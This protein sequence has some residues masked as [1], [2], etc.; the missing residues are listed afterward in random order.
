MGWW[1]ISFRKVSLGHSKMQNLYRL[2]YISKNCFVGT[3]E[4]QKENVQSILNVA[5][6]NN[7]KTGVTGALLWSGD[8]F[9]QVIEGERDT[10]ED[11]FET[12][13]MD[14]RHEEIT[15]LHFEPIDRRSFSEWA[16][17]MAGNESTMRFDIEGI[18]A[19]KDE[20]LM[21]ETGKSLVTVLEELVNRH[22]QI[23]TSP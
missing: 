21:Q 5:Q 11:L 10:L 2:A 7:S 12:I 1:L 8:Y 18:R 19:S 23:S 6:S 16:M 4:D 9:C 15:V 22:Q 14:P 20:I 13:Q 17:A 3:L